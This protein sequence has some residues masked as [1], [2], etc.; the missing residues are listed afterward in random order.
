MH[1]FTGKA[2]FYHRLVVNSDILA[3]LYQPVYVGNFI[4]NTFLPQPG[5]LELT[6]RKTEIMTLENTAEENA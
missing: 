6:R 1:M 2:D 4:A 5:P 3:P